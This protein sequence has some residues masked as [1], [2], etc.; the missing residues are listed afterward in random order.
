MFSTFL[1]Y[2]LQQIL[3]YDQQPGLML[4]IKKHMTVCVIIY[5]PFNE[6][7][8]LDFYLLYCSILKS[9]YWL[10]DH[11]M[12]LSV[13]IITN[14]VIYAFYYAL[15]CIAEFRNV[16]QEATVTY[17]KNVCLHL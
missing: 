16:V 11:T 2:I 15:Q 7:Y 12:C 3:I 4:I 17:E 1:L 6:R 8:S 14:E 5:I 9:F 10:C 13:I